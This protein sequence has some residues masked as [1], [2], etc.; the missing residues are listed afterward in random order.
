MRI[1][2]MAL[3]ILLSAL[4]APAPVSAQSQ[5]A[6]PALVIGSDAFD[7]ALLDG[8]L[9][10]APAQ[11][12]FT[13]NATKFAEEYLR[14]GGAYGLT[15]ED[16]DLVQAAELPDKT[17]DEQTLYDEFNILSIS[18]DG[19]KLLCTL[20]DL[21]MVLDL[22]AQKM[23]LPWTPEQ[24]VLPGYPELMQNLLRLLEP[25]AISWSADGNHLAFSFPRNTLVNMR[26]ECNVWHVDLSA[27]VAH[28]LVD[29]PARVRI[30]DR[31]QEGFPGIPFRAAF[32]ANAPVLYYELYRAPS[33][34]QQD[35]PINRVFRYDPATGES[36][37]IAEADAMLTTASPMFAIAGSPVV[38]LVHIQP[39]GG[40]GLFLSNAG[41]GVQPVFVPETLGTT[42]AFLRR[43][44]LV[45]VRGERAVSLYKADEKTIPGIFV[46]DL[47]TLG[48][49]SFG[50][51]Y[52]I[53]PESA[54][55]AAAW[56]PLNPKALPDITGKAA[57]DAAC[58]AMLE[59]AATGDILVPTNASLSP[60]GKYL[61]VMGHLRGEAAC[62][63]IRL[64]D[65]L[66]NRVDL[67]AFSGTANPM[68]G[69]YIQPTNRNARGLQ[70][71]DNNR[72][73]VP[74]G[75]QTK[76]YELAIQ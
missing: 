76:I 9:T 33:P 34:Q 3:V 48:A 39:E 17:I 54:G 32:D 72:L 19:N 30:A 36:V 14:W 18:P 52:C 44:T 35:D 71:V 43:A 46:V 38:D 62:Y 53:V 21:L 64:E 5:P 41:E 74:D 40:V 15:A 61:L 56:K 49:A 12:S 27:G 47:S 1:R 25:N 70:W 45:D 68:L 66:C 13:F 50:A 57:D 8:A 4:F 26:M 2:L 37:V 51:I 65:G 10:L 69:S 23:I 28:P 55:S 11:V 20:D 31:H 6:Q 42:K 59:A 67:S 73:L 29:L 75:E 58:K 24:D 60:D 22:A 16:F 7:Q 63:L